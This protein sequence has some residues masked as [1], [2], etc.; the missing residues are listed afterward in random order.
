MKGI[1]RW[2]AD[3]CGCIIDFEIDDEQIT[4]PAKVVGIIQSCTFH[5]RLVDK[6]N[7]YEVVLEEN[8][9]KNNFETAMKTAAPEILEEVP[10]TI[11]DMATIW[12]RT[13]KAITNGEKLDESVLL[14]GLTKPNYCKGMKYTWSFDSNR[15]LV[16]DASKLPLDAKTNIR[17]VATTSQFNGKVIII[18]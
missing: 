13:I 7:H 9:R 10:Q 2:T 18:G 6:V 14:E 12:R 4:L 17:E 15:N 16:V 11:Q 3:T 1:T 5:N 8:L